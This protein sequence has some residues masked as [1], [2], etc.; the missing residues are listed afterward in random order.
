M[1]I[2][3]MKVSKNLTVD[4]LITFIN[5]ASN[6]ESE[7]TIKGGHF[8]IDAKSILGVITLL[9][10]GMDITIIT[11]GDDEEEAL[12]AIAEFLI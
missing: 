6:F 1:R 2:K 5:T 8:T 3:E 7:I 9:M 12:K 10:A 4:E 11:R